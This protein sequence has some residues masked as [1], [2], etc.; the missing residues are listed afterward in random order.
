MTPASPT[1]VPSSPDTTVSPPLA[2]PLADLH[3]AGDGSGVVQA[4]EAVRRIYEACDPD[5]ACL[6]TPPWIRSELLPLAA[7]LDAEKLGEVLYSCHQVMEN[8]A[9]LRAVA[10]LPDHKFSKVQWRLLYSPFVKEFK[11]RIA[12]READERLAFA[13]DQRRKRE[14]D[15][16]ADHPDHDRSNDAIGSDND[17]ALALVEHC[18]LDIRHVHGL[19]WLA[20]DGKRWA[21]DEDRVWAM[22]RRL[23]RRRTEDALVAG[24]RERINK[25]INLESA[26]RIKGCL[27]LAMRDKRIALSADDLDRDPYLLNVDNG[28]LDL[29]TKLLGPHSRTDHITKLCPVVYQPG[30]T[31]PTLTKFLA[32]FSPEHQAFLARSFGMSLT[33]DVSAETLHLIQGPGGGGKTTLLEGVRG[34]MGDYAKKFPIANFLQSRH[35]RAAEGATP[36]RLEL[37]GCRMVYAAEAGEAARLDAGEL[38]ELTGGE[39]VTARALYELP[40]TF[41]PTWHIWIVTNYDP[42]VS[43][44]DD[45]VWRRMVK[46]FFPAI[47][48]NDRDPWVKHHFNSDPWCKTAL[49]NFL[50]DGCFDWLSRHGGRKGLAIPADIEA[51]TSEYREAQDPLVAWVVEAGVVFAPDTNCWGS[52]LRES[53]SQWCNANHS[54][55]W[56]PLRFNAWLMAKGASKKRAR[57][58]EEGGR[59]CE[60]WTGVHLTNGDSQKND[61]FGTTPLAEKP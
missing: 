26:T 25:A 59:V 48:V 39:V 5:H 53:Y 58:P 51:T 38:K 10:K 3:T 18:H 7:M 36:Q 13:R 56:Q 31:H 34:L 1:P 32:S 29:G 30:I 37:R 14:T 28:T 49:L 43:A 50:V 45:G 41:K 35:G 40:V 47:P 27:D 12:K 46:M 6:P 55:P 23:A 24:D 60:Q 33:G 44:D 52:Q 2:G 8:A 57:N 61:V 42:I 22:A 21:G 9:Q 16:T 11:D 4:S 15:P 17:A 54:H 20:W 19:G